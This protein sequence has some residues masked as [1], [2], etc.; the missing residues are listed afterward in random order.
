MNKLLARILLFFIPIASFAD[1]PLPPPA[2]YKICN[3]EISYC[4]NISPNIGAVIYKIE[5]DAFN[6]VEAYRVPGWHRDAHL[7]ESGEYFLSGYGGLNL[8]N[9]D[10]NQNTVILTIWKNGQKSHEIKL[11]QVLNSMSS[12]QRTSSHYY[13][14]NNE[15]F[16]HNG[17]VE[18]RTVEGNR[19]L[20][21][22]ETGDVKFNG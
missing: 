18:I 10:A 16:T 11:G 22:P 9:L 13:W 5:G 20:V 12:L 6:A 19:I 4:A 14:G 1:A 21:N 2:S 8:V 7:S 17:E 15:G 3:K